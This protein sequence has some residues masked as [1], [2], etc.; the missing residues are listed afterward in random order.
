[1]SIQ[2]QSN[3]KFLVFKN[4]RVQDKFQPDSLLYAK[5]CYTILNDKF[6]LMDEEHDEKHWRFEVFDLFMNESR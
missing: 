5:K 3:E 4:Q 6:F 1:M 2:H